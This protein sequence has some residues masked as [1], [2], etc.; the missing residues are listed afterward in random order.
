[1]DDEE[2]GLALIDE[3]AFASTAPEP[4]HLS[5][6]GTQEPSS[7]ASSTHKEFENGANSHLPES[8]DTSIPPMKRQARLRFALL[9]TYRRLFSLA[10]AGNLAAF[11]YI[12]ASDQKLLNLVNA[13]AANLLAAGLARQ[14]R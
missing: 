11:I 4:S 7:A 1:M 13:A 6:E 8:Q 12:M 14:V 5:T 10:F 9:S 2:K 3:K